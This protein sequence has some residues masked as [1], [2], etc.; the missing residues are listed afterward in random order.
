MVSVSVET[1]EQT[2]VRLRGVIAQA[3]LVVHDGAWCFEE[4]PADQAP[5]LTAETLAVVRDEESWSR[6]APE[7]PGRGGVERFGIF[8]FHFP[9]DQD[10]SG[11][12]GW[13]ATHLKAEL[14]TG[15]FVICGSNQARGGIYD[16]WGCPIDMLAEAVAVVEALRTGRP[17]R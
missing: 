2:E 5:A 10:N 16:Y 1:A 12:V 15:V 17:G 13:L 3:E 8:S 7:V 14:G 11:F 9:A 6:L 4:F